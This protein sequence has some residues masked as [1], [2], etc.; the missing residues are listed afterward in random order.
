VRCGTGQGLVRLVKPLPLPLLSILLFLTT[1]EGPPP[2]EGESAWMVMPRCAGGLQPVPSLIVVG[3]LV[4]CKEGMKW[5]TREVMCNV[6][7]VRVCVIPRCRNPLGLHSHNSGVDDVANTQTDAS[8]AKQ[9]KVGV[10]TSSMPRHS[11][12]WHA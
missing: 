8:K 5:K 12:N 6:Q 1:V 4:G 3:L 2:A 10:V 11:T 9:R 7:C